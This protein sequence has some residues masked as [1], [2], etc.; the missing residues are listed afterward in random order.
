MFAANW[1]RYF[2]NEAELSYFLQSS[3]YK[4]YAEQGKEAIYVNDLASVI[5]I[6]HQY[7]GYFVIGISDNNP[8]R[9]KNYAKFVNIFGKIK[10]ICSI[11]AELFLIKPQD[12]Y[13]E[14]SHIDGNL[15]DDRASNLCYRLRS[16]RCRDSWIKRNCQEE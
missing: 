6:C 11:V 3:K 5:K 13:Y 2:D 12:G 4:K 10:K 14:L 1:M 9:A 7:S 16:E 15:C 8:D